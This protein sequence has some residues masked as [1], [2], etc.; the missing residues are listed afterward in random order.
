MSYNYEWIGEIRNINDLI[1]IGERKITDKI[2]YNL[3]INKI[4]NLVEPLKELKKMV[5][6]KE[7]KNIIFEELIYHL[8][9]LDDGNNEMHH[10]AI[11]G[12]PGVGKTKLA[13]II[14]KIYNKLGFLKKDTVVS[15]KRDDFVAGYLGQTAIKTRKVLDKALGGVLLIDEAY[16]L[17]N[18]DKGGD[19]YSNEVIDLLTHYLE[20]HKHEL[21]CV[22]AGYKDA[23][24]NRFFAQNEGLSRRFTH[25]YYIEGYE[26]KELRLIF[27]KMVIKNK[28]TYDEFDIKNEWFV[29]HKDIFKNFGGDIE[30]L[31]NCCKKVHS[32][33]ILSISDEIKLNKAKKYIILDDIKEGVKLMKKISKKDE[34]EDDKLKMLNMYS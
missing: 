16:S 5:G 1:K 21:V 29:E 10:T 33:R 25:R 30:T 4:K 26:P 3:N 31:F 20:E 22:I 13:H 17:G 7:I 9:E 34:N 14:A 27:K 19:S 18:S 23:L 28:W 15:V 12:P 6:L 2:R 24:E 32:R 8:Q 11:F